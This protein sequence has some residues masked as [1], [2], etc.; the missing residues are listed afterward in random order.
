MPCDTDKNF[1]KNTITPNKYKK[2]GVHAHF[3]VYL[4]LNCNKFISKYLLTLSN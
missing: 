2:H 4:S 3:A 1:I